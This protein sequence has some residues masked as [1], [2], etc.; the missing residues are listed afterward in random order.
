MIFAGLNGYFLRIL[1]Y[2]LAWEP[3][4]PS[5]LGVVSPIFRG[6]KPSFL[7][8]LGSEGKKGIRSV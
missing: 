5:F 1:R 7:M 2:V 8:V 3:M 4:V 6:L